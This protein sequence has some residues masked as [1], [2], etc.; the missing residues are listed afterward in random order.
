MK[1]FSKDVIL[2]S[3]IILVHKIIIAKTSI[4]FWHM[5][6]KGSEQILVVISIV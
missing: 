4:D 2:A 6:K 1:Y 3:K 5:D